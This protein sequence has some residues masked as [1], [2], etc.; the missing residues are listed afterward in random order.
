M[1]C[2]LGLNGQIIGSEKPGISDSKAET[3]VIQ[4]KIL[5]KSYLLQ[6]WEN[7]QRPTEPNTLRKEIGKVYQYP[8]SF[9]F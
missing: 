7:N 9:I 3:H 1:V 6:N 2:N 5:G 4:S 8:L